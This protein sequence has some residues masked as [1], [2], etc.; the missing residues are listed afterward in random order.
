MSGCPTATRQNCIQEG[1]FVRN[2]QLVLVT[3]AFAISFSV[4]G[5][6]SA[7]APQFKDLYTLTTF[8]TSVI[9]AI[10]VILG[11]LFRIPI[12]ILADRYGGRRVFSALLAFGIIPAAGIALVHSYA[13]LLIFGFLLG[14]AGSSFAVGVSFTSKWFGA[15]QQGMALGVFGVGNIGQSV[16][17][18]FGPRLSNHLGWEWVFWLFGT[19]SLAWAIVFWVFARDAAVGKPTSLRHITDVFLYQRL[20]W[21]LA[22]FYFITFGGFVALGIY[23]PTLLK[24][25]F[26]LSLADAGLRTAG[27]V[28]VAT[29]IRPV[30]GWLSDR[31][32]GGRVLIVVFAALVILA[33]LLTSTNFVLFTIGALGGAAML[34]LGNGAV[35]KLVPQYFPSEIGVVT[36]LVGALG[37]LGGFFP[38][39]VLGIVKESTGTYAVGFILLALS[40][41]IALIANLLLFLGKQRGGVSGVRVSGSGS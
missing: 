25:Q 35:F 10:P 9:I 37:G 14:V 40:A 7:L 6:I 36:G 11:S 31:V 2:R 17:V 8:E 38:P 19:L 21:L 15:A 28:V 26:H 34:G 24:G 29:L 27:F 16:A 5:L 32:G 13:A 22:F 41:L 39:I 12:G 3:M 20:S 18:F 33:L 30:G 23:L 4:W 1:I